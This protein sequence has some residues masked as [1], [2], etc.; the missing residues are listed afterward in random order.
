MS[1]QNLGDGDT[2]PKQHARTRRFTLG[3]PR[4][5]AVSP[6]G[7]RVVFVRS[8]GGNDPLNCLWVLDVSTGEERLIADP[9][10][11][12]GGAGEANLPP[13]ERAR[14]ERARE[15]GGGIVT[16]ATDAEVRVASFPLDGRLFVAG[17]LTG[18]SAS[19]RSPAPSSIRD[20]IRPPAGSPTSA[21]A[22]CASAS[23]TAG[24]GS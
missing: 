15:A 23:S 18:G 16:Y 17:L 22:V 2:F 21:A 5:I 11:L 4:T 19:S 1:D 3:E 14:R 7:R 20:P 10:V 12:L 8:R 9:A 13:E 6:D 24:R